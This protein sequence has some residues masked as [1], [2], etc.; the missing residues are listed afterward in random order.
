[1]QGYALGGGCELALACDIVVASED[2]KFGQ[3]EV[4]VGVIPGFGGTQ[5]LPRAVGLSYSKKL[6][7]TGELVDAR[8]AHRA[9]LVAMVVP[10]E[11]LEEKTRELARKVLE[12]SRIAVALAKAAINQGAGMAL[13]EGLALEAKNFAMCFTTRDQ[14]EG[15]Q[16]F[17]EKRRPRFIGR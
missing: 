8:E 10:R 7:F 5:R 11:Q 13:A 9:G 15:M 16:A 3:P 1:V 6:I 4:N 14:K 17:L 2:A 12:N